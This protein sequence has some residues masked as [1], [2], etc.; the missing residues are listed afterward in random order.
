MTICVCVCVCMC[1]CARVCARVC[2]RLMRP[3]TKPETVIHLTHIASAQSAIP[4]C[5]SAQAAY[6][7]VLACIPTRP[8]H[9]AG[10]ETRG[11]ETG[12]TQIHATSTTTTSTC[13]L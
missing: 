12:G 6:L 3:A 13:A 5:A 4:V 7:S 11:A 2:D 1:V 9:A 10:H 8:P